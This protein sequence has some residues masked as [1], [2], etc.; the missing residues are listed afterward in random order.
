[1]LSRRGKKLVNRAETPVLC[2]VAAQTLLAGGTRDV[3]N[4]RTR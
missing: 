3:D 1:M 2:R 4:E